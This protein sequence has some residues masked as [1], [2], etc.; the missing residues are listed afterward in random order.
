MPRRDAE[1]VAQ[2]LERFLKAFPHPVTTVLTDNGSEFTDRF[3]GARWGRRANGTG[4]P[5]F[6]RVCARHGIQHRLTRPFHPQTN[7]MVER[8]NRRLAEAIRTSRPPAPT[9]AKTSSKATPNATPSSTPSSTAI[10]E[11]ASGASTTIHPPSV[12][13]TSRDTTRRRE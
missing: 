7:G 4:E 5:A 8:F 1:T 12:S 10:I 11:H 2:C 3:G 9:R 6:D 13:L